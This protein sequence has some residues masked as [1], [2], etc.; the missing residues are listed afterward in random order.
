MQLNNIEFA[1]FIFNFSYF[2][3]SKR[4]GVLNTKTSK[5]VNTK[6]DRSTNDETYDDVDAVDSTRARLPHSSKQSR[7][8][9]FMTTSANDVDSNKIDAL[10]AEFFHACNV[11]LHACESKYFKNLIGALRPSYDIPNRY[12]LAAILDKAH[13]K[14]DR[15]SSK[16]NEPAITMTI[17][18]AKVKL[19]SVDVIENAQNLTYNAH[20]ANLLADDILKSPKYV[21]LMAQVVTVQKEFQRTPFESRLLAAG[22]TKVILCGDGQWTSQ[23]A[24]AVSFLKNLDAMKKVSAAC[25][26]E[27]QGDQTAIRPNLSVA[28]L[29]LNSDFVDAVQSLTNMLDAVVELINYCQRTDVSIADIVEKWLDLLRP[30]SSEQ[31]KFVVERC[32]TSNVFTNISMAANFIHP[33]YRGKKLNDTQR[34]DVYEYIFEAFDAEGLESLRLFSLSEGSFDSLVKK[35]LKSPI[36]FWHFARQHGHQQVA[37][38]A[39]ELLSL[40]DST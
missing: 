40:K 4:C 12:R 18:N 30:E 29:L 36:T 33:D 5:S 3:C 37:D 38:L 19:D 23:R 7:M 14:M 31:S 17:S 22:G 1:N 28:E 15:Q 2:W 16:K 13:S 26:A 20:I 39:I 34:K 8:T 25:D 6:Y 27:Y 24:E 32:S 11:P 10:M 21:S 35:N 9:Q